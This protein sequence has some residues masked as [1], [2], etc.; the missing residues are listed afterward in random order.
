MCANASGKTKRD[1]PA[2]SQAEYLS[3]KILLCGLV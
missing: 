1:W 3:A 2:M